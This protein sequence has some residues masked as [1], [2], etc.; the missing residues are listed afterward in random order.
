[1]YCINILS[2]APQYFIKTRMRMTVSL[3]S[4]RTH[5]QCFRLHQSLSNECSYIAI[6]IVEKKHRL[7]FSRTHVRYNKCIYKWEKLIA[8]SE[9]G[10]PASPFVVLHQLLLFDECSQRWL[11]VYLYLDA[12]TREWGFIFSR[13]LK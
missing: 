6:S 8:V 4:F 3:Y 11:C 7:S 1:M 12:G 13:F 2:S 9:K 5:E 10:N